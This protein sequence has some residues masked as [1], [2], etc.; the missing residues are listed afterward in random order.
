MDDISISNMV[1][2]VTSEIDS[3]TPEYVSKYVRSAS[4]L[5]LSLSMVWTASFSGK[6]DQI[7]RDMIR[8]VHFAQSPL[9][10]ANE[11]AMTWSRAD[12]GGPLKM[13]RL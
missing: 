6:S 11:P 1:A 8:D 4:S 2:S 5:I 13:F 7:R 9:A 10:I 3:Y 12:S